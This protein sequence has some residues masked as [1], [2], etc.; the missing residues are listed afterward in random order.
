[1]GQTHDFTVGDQGSSLVCHQ[2]LMFFVLNVQYAMCELCRY[3]AQVTSS[4]C[5]DMSYEL[6]CF[7][8]SLFFS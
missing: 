4:E 2:M 5:V 7:K 8:L 1:M 3:V 6:I